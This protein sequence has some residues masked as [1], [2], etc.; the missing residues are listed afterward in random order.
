MVGSQEMAVLEFPLA[1]LFEQVG[2]G[3]L[4]VRRIVNRKKVGPTPA[5]LAD[6]G[7]HIMECVSARRYTLGFSLS[8]EPVIDG[9]AESKRYTQSP[10][11]GL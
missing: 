10:V 2:S 8:P 11:P 1:N 7:Q 4:P 9:D 6:V 5:S 3:N